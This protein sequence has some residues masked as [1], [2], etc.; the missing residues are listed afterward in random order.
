MED[1]KITVAHVQLCS[2]CGCLISLTDTYEKL[3]DVLNNIDLVYCQTLMDVRKIPEA[4]VILVEGGV[5]LDDHHAMEMAKKVR[6]KGKTVVALGACAAVG[7]I[8]RFT[9]GG[10][11]PKPV[12]GS[13][14]SLAELEQT[15]T[16]RYK[17]SVEKIRNALT[18]EELVKK[19]TMQALDK[20]IQSGK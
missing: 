7:G 3:L 10:Q 18:L 9:K 14:S 19:Y 8:I 6:E 20:Y 17:I 2:C 12:Q 1:K 13:F 4:D 5:C 15:E 11:M 16:G